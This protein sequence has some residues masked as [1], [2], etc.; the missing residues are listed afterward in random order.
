MPVAKCGFTDVPGGASGGLL[1]TSYGPTLLVDIGFDPDY[2]Q[3]PNKVPVAGI[4]GLHAL[5]DTGAGESCIDNLLAAQLNLPIVD[6]RHVSGS[7][8]KHEVNVYLAQV[9]IPSLPYTIWGAFA[10]VELKAGGQAHSAL[11]GRTFLASFKMVYDGRTGDV[12]ITS[13]K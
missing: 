8:G 3:A 5:V 12:T 2:T 11:I 13:E 10:G 4:T 7:S 9:H 6:R 1:L